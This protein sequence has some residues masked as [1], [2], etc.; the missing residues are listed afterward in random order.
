MRRRN[1]PAALAALLWMPLLATAGPPAAPPGE[2][3]AEVY[4]ATL[5]HS[6][7]GLTTV[8]NPEDVWELKSFEVALGGKFK[9]ATKKATVAL[10]HHGTN[11]LWAAVFPEKPVEIQAEGPG[12][13]ELATSIF[14]RFAPAE[15][16]R[17]FP[18]KTV[19]GPGPAWRRA[20][21]VRLARHKVAWKWSTPS[22]NPT[23]VQPG[24]VLVDVD[25]TAG[26]RRL[27]GLDRNAAGLEYVADYEDRPLPPSPPVNKAEA[28]ALFDAV[29]EAFDREYAGFVLLPDVDWKKLGKAYR[30]EA[31]KRRTAY[32]VGAVVGDLVAQLQDLHAWVRVGDEWVQGYS[33]ERP[34]NAHWDATMRTCRADQRAGD[35][36][37]WG[38]TEDG[39][40]YVA[41]TALNDAEIGKHF[42]AVL[43]ELGDTYALILDLRFNGGGGED[44]ARDVAGRFV[45]TEA[46]YSLNQ[47]RAGTKHDA[48]GPKLERR[49]APRGPWRYRS[50]VVVLWGRKTLSSAESMALM[51]ATCPQVT[52]MGDRTGGSSG[53]PRRLELDHGLVVNLPRWLDMDPQGR[54]IERLG[55]A[56][57]VTIEAAPED[58]TSERDP[59]LEA[60][61][62]RL[63]AQP[64]GERGPG[65]G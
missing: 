20:Q 12:D 10:G 29:W 51:L 6:P 58:F 55:V 57:E 33:R 52:T 16:E 24:W 4:P 13:G 56:P 44:L 63:R 53:N 48:L 7:T 1:R 47:Y 46:V 2:D 3:L 65:K 41:V 26:T 62:K 37:R 35:N 50:P 43:E 61:L 49:I 39:I 38:R 45:E 64:K 14:L 5:G 28:L 25:T 40:G 9:L 11:V 27:W 60:A 19:K 21:G 23:V 34:L 36:L 30:K 42:D 32:G 59:V 18:P 8:C 54:P 15:I 22:G 31:A 17:V